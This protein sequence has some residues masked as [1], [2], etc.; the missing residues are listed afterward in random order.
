MYFYRGLDIWAP[1]M[2]T[3][4]HCIGSNLFWHGCNKILQAFSDD[5]LTKSPGLRTPRS[6]STR[7]ISLYPVLLSIPAFSPV[8]LVV[9][10]PGRDLRRF[11]NLAGLFRRPPN[12]V[13]GI[14][15]TSKYLAT[16]GPASQGTLSSLLYSL[17]EGVSDN[18]GWCLF[19][20]H[21][22]F[23]FYFYWNLTLFFYLVIYDLAFPVRVWHSCVLYCKAA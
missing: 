17:P 19:F 18:L 1:H 2:L 7:L 9:C 20:L 5:P 13:P 12:K 11:C 15:Y 22:F 23:I 8:Y 14:T 16:Q 6:P 10:F 3:E 21:F 4:K